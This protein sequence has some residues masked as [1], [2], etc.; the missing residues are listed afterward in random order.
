MVTARSAATP[1]TAMARQIRA[2]IEYDSKWGCSI[3]TPAPLL[4]RRERE[5]SLSHRR[6]RTGPWPVM[7]INQE[8]RP[9][10][11]RGLWPAGSRDVHGEGFSLR[12]FVFLDE[13]ERGAPKFC[14]GR[15]T[16]DE[17]ANRGGL[18]LCDR[19]DRL[20][21]HCLYVNW[22]EFF[23]AVLQVGRTLD[24]SGRNRRVL[25]GSCH[26]KQRRRG[27]TGKRMK[28][29][30]VS[31]IPTPEASEKDSE[32]AIPFRVKYKKVHRRQKGL[33]FRGWHQ[34]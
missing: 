16:Q 27:L 11:K 15:L 6:L 5:R 13:R 25:R 24:Q 30:H 22:R 29:W 34:S 17:A 21:R 18:V 7:E 12:R 33:S 23:G 32:A 1:A 10:F 3:T 28:A 9:L 20:F 31:T 2:G 19:L 26:A 8:R 14:L 4:C